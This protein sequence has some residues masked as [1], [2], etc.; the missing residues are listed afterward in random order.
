MLQI[1]CKKLF[2]ALAQTSWFFALLFCIRIFLL[3]I[4]SSQFMNGSGFT[5]RPLSQLLKTEMVSRRQC[6]MKGLC[7]ELSLKIHLIQREFVWNSPIMTSEGTMSCLME[8]DFLRCFLFSSG[9]PGSQCAAGMI[10]NFWFSCLYPRVLRLYVCTTKP[11]FW[12]VEIGFRASC[13]L[14]KKTFYQLTV[15]FFGKYVHV[16]AQPWI[17]GKN[18]GSGVRHKWAEISAPSYLATWTSIINDLTCR[19]LNFMIYGTEW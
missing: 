13:R 8:E 12:G 11:S 9:W 7:S 19:S 15:F 5:V 18:S 1:L 2:H 10:M 3:G 4:S 14:G 16:E 17:R 6:W